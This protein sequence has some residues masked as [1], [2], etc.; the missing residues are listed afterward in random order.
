MKVVLNV[1]DLVRAID[2]MRTILSESLIAEDQRNLIFWYNDGLLKVVTHTEVVNCICGVTPVSIEATDDEMENIRYKELD[3]VLKSY[4]SLKVTEPTTIAFDFQT[5][6]I[7]VEVAEE[8]VDK[9]GVYAEKLYR[10]SK[11]ILNKPR[12]VV[13]RIKTEILSI[14]KAENAEPVAREDMQPYFDTLLPIIKDVKEGI[15]ARLNFVGDYIYTSHN[16][17]V[18]MQNFTKLRNCY[19]LGIAARFFKSFIGLEDVT[20][21]SQI[22]KDNFV[23]LTL[24]N[25]MAI[26]TIKGYNGSKA[27]NT[28]MY[29]RIPSQGV[30]FDKRY[31]VDVLKRFNANEDIG[32]RIDNEEM[33]LTQKSV[34]VAVPFFNKRLNDDFEQFTFKVNKDR[35]SNFILA[36][37]DF[38]DLLFIYFEKM[39]NRKWAVC[40]TDNCMVEVDNNGVTE[41]RH[42]W[43][44]SLT[45]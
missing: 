9:N 31:V 39:E 2:S 5:N 15:G 25:S 41:S 33:V 44:T 10:T 27:F 40:F 26:A 11:F 34:S 14:T 23:M 1:G 20:M 18:F 12:S 16:Y 43:Y 45:M 17:V 35:F 38:G 4:A 19:F 37:K 21:I 30:V 28:K 8:P 7:K 22:E 29:E 24:Q 36:H 42:Y 32:V 3:D 13:Q 6:C